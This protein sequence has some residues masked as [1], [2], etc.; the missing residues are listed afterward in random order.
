MIVIKNNEIIEIKRLI[1]IAK[2]R[3]LSQSEKNTFRNICSKNNIN[4]EIDDEI[5]DG[6]YFDGIERPNLKISSIIAMIEKFDPIDVYDH[7]SETENIKLAI[8]A[9][10]NNRRG[11]PY[12]KN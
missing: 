8:I 3:I 10:N 11:Y 4:I 7:D 12:S 2:T 6:L 9:D 5:L 1:K